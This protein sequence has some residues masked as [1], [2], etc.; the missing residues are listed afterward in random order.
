MTTDRLLYARCLFAALVFV[1][2]IA[3]VWTLPYGPL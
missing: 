2:G 1:L 3:T